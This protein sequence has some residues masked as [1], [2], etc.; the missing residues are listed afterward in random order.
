MIGV[1]SHARASVPGSDCL[2]ARFA[3][4]IS[5]NVFFSIKKSCL[6]YS[7]SAT[8]YRQSVSFIFWNSISAHKKCKWTQELVYSFHSQWHPCMRPLCFRST[9]LGQVLLACPSEPRPCARR[10]KVTL[11]PSGTPRPRESSSGRR[12]PERPRLV[13]IQLALSGRHYLWRTPFR[14][15]L[16]CCPELP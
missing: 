1:H 13:G 4:L 2:I 14:M 3:C 12:A 7:S 15:C 8:F 9:A 10:L 16:F 5:T 6:R 11:L